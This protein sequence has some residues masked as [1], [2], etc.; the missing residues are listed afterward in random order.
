MSQVINDGLNG[1]KITVPTIAP[2]EF[3]AD[4]LE[5]GR[6][7]RVRLRDGRTQIFVGQ[8]LLSALRNG[9]TLVDDPA[10]NAK[11]VITQWGPRFAP[12]AQVGPQIR[13]IG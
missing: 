10:L 5:K 1:A 4:D 12:E 3:S 6:V 11:V 8:L 7:G 13:V 9:G 2:G